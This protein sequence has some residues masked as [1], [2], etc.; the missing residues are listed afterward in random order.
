MEVDSRYSPNVSDW[1]GVEIR[2][3]NNLNSICTDASE[4]APITL[5][6]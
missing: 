6:K 1:L 2:I 3:W 4:A 5:A